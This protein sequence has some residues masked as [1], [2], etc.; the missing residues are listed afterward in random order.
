[1]IDAATVNA[2]TLIGDHINV[3]YNGTTTLALVEHVGRPHP[4]ADGRRWS[5]VTVRL[6]DGQRAYFAAV[7]P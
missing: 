6:E 5:M 1:V 3:R 4:S 7:Q 2:M